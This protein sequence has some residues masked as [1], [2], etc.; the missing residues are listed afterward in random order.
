MSISYGWCGACEHQITTQIFRGQKWCSEKCRKKI[1]HENDGP[2]S[3]MK[4]V[5]KK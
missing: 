3:A 1:M 5:K 4:M 2:D